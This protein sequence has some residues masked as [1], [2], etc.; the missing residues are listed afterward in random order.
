MLL[1]TLQDSQEERPT[2]AEPKFVI[3]NICN[4]IANMKAYSNN[5]VW[6]PSTKDVGWIHRVL[7]EVVMMDKIF[8]TKMISMN[9]PPSQT[10]P[11]LEVASRL[12]VEDKKIDKHKCFVVTI[13]RVRVFIAMAVRHTVKCLN[14]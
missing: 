5:N 6:V 3:K 4:E 14:C 2:H 12:Y 8:S 10:G 9:N 13:T 1:K 7:G 11:S